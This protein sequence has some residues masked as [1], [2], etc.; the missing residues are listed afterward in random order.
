[1]T[2]FTSV[3]ETIRRWVA[4]NKLATE[5]Q[6]VL[7]VQGAYAD[8]YGS[9]QSNAQVVLI[10]TETGGHSWPGSKPGRGKNPSSGIVANDLIWDFF[11]EQV[12]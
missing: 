6:R 8:L 5:S 11:L 3:D 7:D 1:V 9:E 12:R 10:V 4:R 2:D